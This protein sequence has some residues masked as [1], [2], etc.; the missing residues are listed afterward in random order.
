MFRKW[1]SLSSVVLRCGL[2]LGFFRRW[3]T[4]GV[5]II[6]GRC[7]NAVRWSVLSPLRMVRLLITRLAAPLIT[8]RNQRL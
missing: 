4:K 2:G 6:A 1:G 3:L 5:G 8:A 7:L